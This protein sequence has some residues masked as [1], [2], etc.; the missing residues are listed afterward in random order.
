MGEGSPRK[1]LRASTRTAPGEGWQGSTG[2]KAGLP[3]EPQRLPDAEVGRAGGGAS[4]G[5]WG[6]KAGAG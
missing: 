5:Q 2:P 4:R 6:V 3:L 1:V